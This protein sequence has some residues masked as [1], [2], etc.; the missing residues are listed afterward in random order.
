MLFEQPYNNQEVTDI[1]TKAP[2]GKVLSGIPM[3]TQSRYH[4]CLGRK[5][6]GGPRDILEQM[7]MG[8]CIKVTDKELP[9]FVSAQA[10]ADGWV[11]SRRSINKEHWM[12]WKTEKKGYLGSRLK[13]LKAQGRYP[14]T[15]PTANGGC[16]Y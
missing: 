12:L 6:E 11:V 10:Y 13:Y 9:R 16:R 3:P 4:G 2:L 1:I 5:E 15:L 14:F 7:E 8:Q